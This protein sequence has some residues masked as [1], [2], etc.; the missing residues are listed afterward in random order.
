MESKLFGE[1][2]VET[3]EVA[4]DDEPEQQD[5]EVVQ[6]DAD[7]VEFELEPGEVFKGPQKLK[8]AVER[9]RDYTVKTQE[10][11]AMRKAVEDKAQFVEAREQLMTQLDGELSEYRALQAQQ[12]QYESLD[13]NALYNANPGQAMQLRDQRDDIARQLQVKEQAIRGKTQHM[14]GMQSQHADKQWA[15]A[16]EGAKQRI[17]KL[18]PDEDLAMAAQVRALGF[19]DGEFK[20]KLADSRILHAIYKAAKWDALQSGKTQALLRANTAPPVI[21][22]GS[23]DPAMSEKMRN[24]NFAK[25]IKSAKS[26]SEKSE[27]AVQRMTRFFG[28]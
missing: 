12:K 17:G 18:S 19:D 2:E 27:M 5:A 10:L 21:K 14:A 16:T 8:D 20:T 11:A 15:L 9:N 4:Q 24:L 3:P 13:W 22:P 6:E 26:N 7:L 28:K 23:V 1:P 25:Q